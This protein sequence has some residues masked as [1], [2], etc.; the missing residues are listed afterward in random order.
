MPSITL[1]SDAIIRQPVLTVFIDDVQETTA[2]NISLNNITNGISSASFMV[3]NVHLDGTHTIRDAWEANIDVADVK[4]YGG[5]SALLLHGYIKRIGGDRP[6]TI[7][8]EDNVGKYT[9]YDLPIDRTNFIEFAGKVKTS[10]PGTSVDLTDPD[11]V[12]PTW[13]NDKFN[14]KYLI[15]TDNT[16]DESDEIIKYDYSGTD[17]VGR[18]TAHDV[19]L[20]YGDHTDVE[21]IAHE[22]ITSGEG[23]GGDHWSVVFPNNALRKGYRYMSMGLEIENYTIPKSA[24]INSVDVTFVV[25]ADVWASLFSNM[26]GKVQPV[27]FSMGNAADGLRAIK[28]FSITYPNLGTDTQTKSAIFTFKIN[29]PEDFFTHPGGGGSYWEGGFVGFQYPCTDDGVAG[30]DLEKSQVTIRWESLHLTIYY[31]SL[32]F[33]TINEAIVDTTSPNQ[34]TMTTNLNT[35]GVAQGDVAYI[36]QTMNYAFEQLGYSAFVGS[37]PIP[38]TPQLVIN[39][40]TPIARGIA[41]DYGFISAYKLFY[42][43]CRLNAYEYFMEY[44]SDNLYCLKEEDITLDGGTLTG[45]EPI[46]DIETINNIYGAVAVWWSGQSDG[47]NPAVELTGNDNPKVLRVLRKDILEYGTAEAVALDHVA[48]HTNFHR[49]IP[50]SFDTWKHIRVGY[51]YDFTINGVTYSNQICR[52]VSYSQD[53]AY[54]KWS[55]LG[56][57]GGGHTPYTEKIGMKI[58]EMDKKITDNESLAITT[59]FRSTPRH[60]N[61]LGIGEDDHHPKDHEATH[62]SGGGDEL[63]HDNMA[64]VSIDDHHPQIH[65]LNTHT[66]GDNKIFMTKGSVF[67]E[68]GVGTVGTYLKSGGEDQDLE[69]DAL[70]KNDVGLGNVLNAEQIPATEK[71]A[72]NGV[73]TLNAIGQHPPDEYAGYLLADLLY[74]DVWDASA[75]TY[76]SSSGLRAGAFYI[77]SVA[78]TVGGVSFSINDKIIWDAIRDQFDKIAEDDGAFFGH[79]VDAYIGKFNSAVIKTLEVRGKAPWEAQYIMNI[80]PDF[81]TNLPTGWTQNSAT[82]TFHMD[83]DSFDNVVKVVSAASGN[84]LEYAFSNDIDSNGF[85]DHAVDIY[86]KA[87]T[88]GTTGTLRFKHTGTYWAMGDSVEGAEEIV[89]ENNAGNWRIQHYEGTA[90][91]NEGTQTTSVAVDEWTHI[92]IDYVSSEGGRGGD[93]YGEFWV[94]I[95]E[96]K[97]TF[98]MDIYSAIP[99]KFTPAST[100]DMLLQIL[101][102]TSGMFFCAPATT[103][104]N[105]NYSRFANLSHITEGTLEA[106]DIKLASKKAVTI[107]MS[108]SLGAGKVVYMNGTTVTNADGDLVALVTKPA[109]GITTE[110]NY[111]A[112]SGVVYYSGAVAGSIYYVSGTAGALTTATTQTY[113]QRVAIGVATD[114][115]LVFP[116]IDVL[117]S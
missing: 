85:R 34:L 72:A 97:Y 94:W 52:R 112:I 114:Y 43:L 21:Y 42:T 111:I 40:N 63:S 41:Q 58:G 29:N 91:S 89:I 27:F 15:L 30:T 39:N 115:V 96:T 5:N 70:D 92:Q 46:D 100:D 12:D 110:D 20:D 108:H 3:P 62:R 44:D 28:S 4:I 6:L 93:Y 51:L 69:W 60:S 101:G 81:P 50:L 95:N 74:M 2:F 68:I 84:Y 13:D 17:I 26:K 49:S 116:S 107:Y 73:A 103:C 104:N 18:S 38:H 98:V 33:D 9:W 1:T 77:V 90:Q 80:P 36:G 53:G 78:G 7:Y 65:A 24:V 23:Y 71:G 117:T 88:T 54:G 47:D 22:A 48:K 66:Q 102:T 61:L 99:R 57:F 35:V 14:G 11:N 83:E 64:G 75:G 87:D 25:Y 10:P 19:T 31:D 86:I 56:Y 37:I 106:N 55:I 79:L 8:L 45:F 32:N 105:P 59:V 109:I 67:T 16:V 82:L 76:P 113:V